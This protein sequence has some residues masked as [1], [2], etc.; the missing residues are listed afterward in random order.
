MAVFNRYPAALLVWIRVHTHMHNWC[1]Q[2]VAGALCCRRKE[3]I[4]SESLAEKLG[5]FVNEGVKKGVVSGA[6]EK[7]L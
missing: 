6:G 4:V 3:E 2:V 5:S 7:Y 1:R